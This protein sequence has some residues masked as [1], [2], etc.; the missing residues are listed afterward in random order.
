M[1]NLDTPLDPSQFKR[2]GQIK[3][4]NVMKDDFGFEIAVEAVPLPSLGLIYPQDGSL[5]GKETLDIKPMTAREEDILTSRAYIKNGTVLSKLIS[6]CLVDKSIDPDDLV[7]GDRNALLVSL[8]ITGY[9]AS[10]D[11]EVDCPQCSHKSKQSFDLS[12]LGI[13]RLQVEPVSMGQNLFE[14]QLPVTKKIVKVKFLT[15]HDE[16]EMMLT[17]ERKK[18]AG[19]KTDSAIT[20]RLSR[21]IVAVDGITDKNKLSFFVNN[22]PARDSLALRKFLDTHEPGVDMKSWMSCPSCHEQS[23][24]VLPMGASFFWPE[25]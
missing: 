3:V 13:K 22:I 6:S 19:M 8:R 20:D 11:V 21:S 18:K 16:R 5:F 10:Y 25:S 7:S 17:N 23:E 2:E 24:V 1:S 12:Q 15:G 9:G 14:V 4:S